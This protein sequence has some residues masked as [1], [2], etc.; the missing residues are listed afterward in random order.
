M[1]PSDTRY[2][3]TPERQAAQLGGMVPPGATQPAVPSLWQ[4]LRWLGNFLRFVGIANRARQAAARQFAE[5]Q[6]HWRAAVQRVPRL[7]RAALLETLERYAEVGQP[8][9][10]FHLRLASAMSG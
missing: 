2:G 3:V 9:L 10:L 6:Q 4:R 7:E 1:L 8:F 5:V